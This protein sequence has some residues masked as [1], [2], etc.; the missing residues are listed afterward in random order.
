VV[1]PARNFFRIRKVRRNRRITPNNKKG[2]EFNENS[3]TIFDCPA[4]VGGFVAFFPPSRLPLSPIQ[5][6]KSRLIGKPSDHVWP[7]FS[8]DRGP[9]SLFSI[10][11]DPGAASGNRVR[12]ASNRLP[13][14]SRNVASSPDNPPF[15]CR[16]WIASINEFRSTVTT[17]VFPFS[18]GT[19]S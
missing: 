19:F 7:V 1:W 18:A 10:Y 8:N 9:K 4:L 6:E 2:G 11:R 3:D 12:G 5:A 14:R 17:R 15:T 16:P 13:N